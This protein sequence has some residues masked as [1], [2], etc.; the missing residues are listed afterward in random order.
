MGSVPIKA[1]P[2]NREYLNIPS[3]VLIV[4]ILPDERLS[5]YEKLAAGGPTSR[6]ARQVALWRVRVIIGS[7]RYKENASG[8][9]E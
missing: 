8:R 6:S 7:N 5:C 3:F 1:Y 9:W 2:K 4:T